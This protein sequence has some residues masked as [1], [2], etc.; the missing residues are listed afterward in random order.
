MVAQL[1]AQSKIGLKDQNVAPV[2]GYRSSIRRSMSLLPGFFYKLPVII[3]LF[4]QQATG[5]RVS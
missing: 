3:E 5:V 4:Q 1:N 2:S